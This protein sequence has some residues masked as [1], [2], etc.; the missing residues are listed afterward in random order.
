MM[1]GSLKCEIA[2][3]VGAKFA[4]IVAVVGRQQESILIFCA[5]E[6]RKI[7]YQ[8]HI[9]SLCQATVLGEILPFPYRVMFTLI[10]YSE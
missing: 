8:I 5:I 4:D 6:N 9:R 1:V 3:S 2:I 10:P 7:V